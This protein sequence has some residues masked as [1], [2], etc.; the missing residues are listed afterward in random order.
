MKNNLRQFQLKELS[1]F[2][3]FVNFC[4]ENKIT[5]Y[6][7]GGTLLGAI[8]HEGFIPWDDD[9]DV[10]IPREDYDRFIELCEKNKP[11]FELHTFNNDPNH[12]RYFARIEDPTLT[13]KRTDRI[14][15]EISSAWIDVFPLD[16]MPNN[17]II[18]NIHK[19]YILY[20]RALYKL[21]CF[22]QSANINKKNRPLI[23]KVLI[24]IGL[25]FPVEKMFNTKK[26][27][28]KLDKALKRF[29]YNK[30]NYLVNAMG[31]YKFNEMFHKKYYGEGTYY[32]FEDTKIFGP[33]D[34]DTVCKQL[35]GDYMTPPIESERNH[36]GSEIIEGD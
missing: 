23:E 8:R 32:K 4:E 19:N 14:K 22:S 10:G 28:L 20:R 2:K 15:E 16:G 11:C 33:N 26:Q 12:I 36:H 3:K 5:Y 30:S 18:R 13:I 25:I 7:L 29:P 17:R 1:L 24:K 35:Y 6:A 27:L 21:S 31:A 9:M 34:Y